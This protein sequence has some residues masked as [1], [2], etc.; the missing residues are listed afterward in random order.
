M[1][2]KHT[3]L[4]CRVST[5][6]QKKYGYS[7]EVQKKR[8]LEYCNENNISNYKWY[9]DEGKSGGFISKRPDMINL[10]NNLKND[11]VERIIITKLDRFSRNLMEF[12]D[13]LALIKEKGAEFISL[14]DSIDTSSPQGRAFLNLQMTMYELER[15]LA[16]QRTEEVQFNLVDQGKL[17]TRLPFG[18][19][20][21]KRK[22]DGK[23]KVVKWIIVEAEAEIVRKIHSMLKL[24]ISKISKTLNMPYNSVKQIANNKAYYGIQRY[25]DVEY[26]CKDYDA[27]LID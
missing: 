14:N 11:M 21:I 13:L 10:I 5:F 2:E 19:K 20:P 24:P 4:Y 27:I 17:I 6:E 16:K 25:K 9:I 8:E 22:V 23:I 3:A 26:K 7:I 12:L 18:Y 1:I 15:E